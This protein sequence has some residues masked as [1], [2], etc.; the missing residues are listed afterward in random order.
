MILP[1]SILPMEPLSAEKVPSGSDYIHSVKWDGVRQLVYLEN[2]TVRI[3][4]RK[5]NDRTQTYPELHRLNNFITGDGI[6]IDGEVVAIID[7]RASFNRVMKRDFVRTLETA[8]RLQKT[9]PITYMA[10]D[11]LYYNGE[12]TMDMGLQE[13]LE[14]LTNIVVETNDFFQITNHIDTGHEL[15]KVT[16][17][18]HLE[19]IVSKHK[20]STYKAG[21]KHMDWFK[22]KHFRDLNV[23]VGGYTYKNNLVNS[24][25]VGAYND[26]GLFYLGNAATGLN[27]DEIKMLTKELVKLQRDS[28]PFTNLKAAKNQFWVEPKLT[29]KVSYLEITEEGRLRHPTIEGFL[30][31]SPEDCTLEEAVY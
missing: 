10:F 8:N 18:L 19:G 13:R 9:I 1:C 31:I 30:A 17:D 4:N 12:S 7:G 21:K 26:G 23:V 16:K 22:V 24:L 2:K 11:L 27:M 14:L 6:V 29:L 20:N 15:F 25:S 3:H 5:L 28:S